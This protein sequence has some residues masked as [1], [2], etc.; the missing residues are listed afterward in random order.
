MM[1]FL[2]AVKNIHWISSIFAID[3]SKLIKLPTSYLLSHSLQPLVILVMHLQVVYYCGLRVSYKIAG[4]SD[5]N[6][7][8]L[9]SLFRE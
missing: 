5:G 3:L 8:G 7:A 2:A 4:K 1:W 6:W 9:L